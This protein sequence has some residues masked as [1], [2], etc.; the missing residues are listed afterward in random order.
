[1]RFLKRW[2]TNILIPTLTTLRSEDFAKQ[3]DWIGG[4]LFPINQFLLSATSAINGN[5]TFG[6]N[7]PCQTQTFTFTYGGAS[8]FPKSFLWKLASKPVELRVCQA[9]EDANPIA[10]VPAWNY[11]NGQVVVDHFVKL[12]VDGV[13]SLVTGSDYNIVLRGQP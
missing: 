10:L 6:D 3:R 5:I 2:E 12:S 9:S 7:I 1:M 8:D 4:L 11:N 13:S